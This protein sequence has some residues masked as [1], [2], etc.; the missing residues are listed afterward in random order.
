MPVL[1][2]Q[3]TPTPTVIMP[4]YPHGHL[5]RHHGRLNDQQFVSALQQILLGLR[6]LHARRNI[7]RDLKP[8]NLLVK[9]DMAKNKL[10]VVIADF[11]FSKT[12]TPTNVLLKAFYGTLLYAAP[13]ISPGR[14]DEGYG[15]NIDIWAAGVIIFGCI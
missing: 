13:E 3:L 9:L 8:E 5:G 6:H 7:H 1:D 11:N 10:A 12:L 15:A 2:F 4:Y 14:S